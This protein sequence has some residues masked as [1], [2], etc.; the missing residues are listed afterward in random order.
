MMDFIAEQYPTL[1]IPIAVHN[2]NSNPM[3]NTAYDTGM[4]ALISGYP[5]G[6]VDRADGEFDPIQFEAQMMN[7]L[8]E[9]V[10][11]RVQHN[12]AY[13]PTTRQIS[14]ESRL[15]FQEA[16]NGNYRIA[17]VITED[18]VTGTSSGYNQQNVY[19]GGAN[20]PM[21]GY[22]NLPFSVPAAQM[23]YNHVA[24]QIV[25]GF[26][27]AANSVPTTNPAGS[28]HSY[29]SNWTHPAAQDVTQM[30]AITLLINNATGEIVNGEQTAIPFTIVD[31]NEPL[32]ELVS[33][34]VFPNPVSEKATLRLNLQEQAEVQ[35]RLTD[36]LGKVVFE[37][38]YG[39]LSGEQQLAIR[40]K[41]QAAGTY[42]L[43]V[44][45]D[46]HMVTKPL[47]VLK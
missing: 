25:G 39:K 9:P 15:K 23:V 42:M 44:N 37:A 21:G 43:S 27:G 2:G 35:V 29:T 38:N 36:L 34:E 10:P 18:D 46:G 5:S 28:E 1:A 20:G 17:V 45:A 8:A 47:V 32:S 41:D 22:E 4:G 16:V 31:A 24:R 33:V 19:S 40:L 13:N 26:G 6:L 12:V 11:V 7:R 30:H 14:V 3:R